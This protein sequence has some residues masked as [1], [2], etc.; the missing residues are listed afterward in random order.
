[1]TFS[2]KYE[3]I[4]YIA[5]PWFELKFFDAFLNLFLNLNVFN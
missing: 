2:K 3:M 5:T 1:M 4:F